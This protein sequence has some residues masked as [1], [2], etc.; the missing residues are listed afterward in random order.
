MKQTS[1]MDEENKLNRLR[2]LEENRRATKDAISTSPKTSFIDLSLD[3]NVQEPN[4]E[5]SIVLESQK[6]TIFTGF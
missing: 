5:S 6:V 4:N 2:E 3:E 1:C